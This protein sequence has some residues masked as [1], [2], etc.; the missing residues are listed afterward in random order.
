MVEMIVSSTATSEVMAA[1][2]EVLAVRGFLG[3]AADLWLHL[4]AWD[5]SGTGKKFAAAAKLV[6]CGR[7]EQAIAALRG[8]PELRALLGW[9][10]LSA[11]GADPAE[12]LALLR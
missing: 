11:P 2:A 3:C 4:L 8:R 12:L 1:V 9:V 6:S 10:F 7:R 5:Q